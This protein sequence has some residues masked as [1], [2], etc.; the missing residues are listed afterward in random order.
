MGTKLPSFLVVDATDAQRR[1]RWGARCTRT[2]GGLLLCVAVS[3]ITVPLAGVGTAAARSSV[4]VSDAK[5]T[6]YVADYAASA[7]D[8]FS[9]GANGNVAP[10][11]RITGQ[12]SGV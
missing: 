2:V 6:I 7:I 12:G 9:P 5:G 3:A 11:R 1:H 8:V 10:I 4:A